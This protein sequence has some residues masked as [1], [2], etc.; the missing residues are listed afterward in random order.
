MIE[1]IDPD[2][3]VPIAYGDLAAALFALALAGFTFEEIHP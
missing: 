2:C 3:W 1:W